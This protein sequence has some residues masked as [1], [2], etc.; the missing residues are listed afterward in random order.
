[1]SV[2]RQGGRRRLHP[3]SLPPSPPP[4]PPP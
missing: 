4:R 2:H 3:S 1:V